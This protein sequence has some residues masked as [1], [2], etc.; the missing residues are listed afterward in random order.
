[1]VLISLPPPHRSVSAVHFTYHKSNSII[2]I[3]DPIIHNCQA[4]TFRAWGPFH[5]FDHHQESDFSNQQPNRGILYGAAKFSS[6]IVEVFG[7]AGIIEPGTKCVAHLHLTRDLLLLDLRGSGAMQAG[8]VSAIAKDADRCLTQSW[9]KYF[10]EHVDIYGN[11]DGLIYANAHNDE[12][13]IAL[14]ERATKAI[15]CKRRDV[16]PLK[17]DI[18]RPIIAEIA[19]ANNLWIK[20]Y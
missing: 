8:T 2:R 17:H 15:L 20:P 16:M 4:R 14:Y 7:D 12:D 18:L 1:L 13:S 6:C 5:R 10:Y 3:F 19:L 11:I 9:S